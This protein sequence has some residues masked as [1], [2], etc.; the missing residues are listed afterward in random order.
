MRY[1]T[2]RWLMLILFG[3]TSL[4]AASSQQK[5]WENHYAKNGVYAEYTTRLIWQDNS[6]VGR[7]KMNYAEAKQYCASL[8]L[9]SAHDWRL[10]TASELKALYGSESRMLNVSHFPSG[11]FWTSTPLEEG[12]RSYIQGV[13]YPGGKTGYTNPK[14]KMLV[15]CVYRGKKTVS[16][17]VA[18]AKPQT[19]KHA[20]PAQTM[21]KKEVSAK[22][23]ERQRKRAAQAAE[24][25]RREEMRIRKEVERMKAEAERLK[26]EQAKLAQARFELL[27]EK[28]VLDMK[29]GLAWQDD[30]DNSKQLMDWTQASEYC[31]SLDIAG[32]RDWQLPTSEELQ[33]LY[34][35]PESVKHR[36]D[37]VY[38]SGT[39]V[40]ADEGTVEYV[41]FK[42]GA[43]FWTTKNR[44]FNVRCVRHLEPAQR[45]A[46]A[47]GSHEEAKGAAHN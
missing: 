1:K 37:G 20:S 33:S 3:C 8:K 22:Q 30:S 15:R 19:K 31:R 43:N 28:S 41:D 7:K 36:T 26:R 42:T 21:P 27:K 32:Y 40:D 6:A 46:A 16:A 17:P 4:L 11:S 24:A 14:N 38:W 18:A 10:P 44:T 2:I 34:R 39:V 23:A 45:V 9:G 13:R 35:H 5:Y 12:S 47:N 29:D 25:K